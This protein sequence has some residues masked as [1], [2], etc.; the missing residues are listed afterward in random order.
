VS[1]RATA[2]AE[3]FDFAVG[4][5]DGVIEGDVSREH[6]ERIKMLDHRPT[7]LQLRLNGLEL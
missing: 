1:D 7:V 2:G 5:P 4:Q 3:T 6:A